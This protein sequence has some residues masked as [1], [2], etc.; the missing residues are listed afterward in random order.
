MD[1]MGAG[2][3]KAG[4]V[5]SETCRSWHPAL[6][7][8]GE[9]VPIH[10][11]HE[12]SDLAAWT[13]GGRI[14]LVTPGGPLPDRLHGVAFAA[15]VDLPRSDAEWEAVDGR[16]D[17]DEPPFHCPAHLDAA[18]GVIVQEPDGRLWIVAP[19]NGFGGAYVIP[20][21]RTDGMSMQATAIKEGFEESGLQVAITGFI[22]D[23]DRTRTRTRYY[24][25]RR[26]GGTP[27]QMG[28]ESQAVLLVPQS[29]LGEYL[30]GTANASVLAALRTS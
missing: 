11:P 17:I 10:R 26:V 29:Q 23:F 8:K 2:M 20:K 15:W 28:W 6:N 13:D 5:Q 27:A 3:T 30:T 1:E 19:T 24:R 16:A 18:A 4:V 21:G 14:A 25:A 22:G 12:A 7:S 9:Q